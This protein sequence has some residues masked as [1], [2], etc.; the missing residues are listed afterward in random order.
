MHHIVVGQST[1][2]IFCD[3]RESSKFLGYLT[4]AVLGS[5]RFESQC[6]RGTVPRAQQQLVHS[7]AGTTTKSKDARTLVCKDQL[8]HK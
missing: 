4:D 6:K 2:D 7:I 1:G 3:D 5:C 8:S